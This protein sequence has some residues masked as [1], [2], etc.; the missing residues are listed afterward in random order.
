MEPEDIDMGQRIC[1]IRIQVFPPGEPDG[2][3]LNISAQGRTK[4]SEAVIEEPYLRVLIVPGKSQCK[5]NCVPRPNLGD[6][7]RVYVQVPYC[8]A[9]VVLD[10]NWSADLIG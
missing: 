2:V 9:L 8:L 5:V 6:P 10:T 3:R 1:R 4:V 7:V